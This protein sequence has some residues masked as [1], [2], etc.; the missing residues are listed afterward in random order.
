MW[1]CTG[2]V[3]P[4]IFA[5]WNV[6]SNL[7]Q[8]IYLKTLPAGYS[9]RNR[10]YTQTWRLQNSQSHQNSHTESTMSQWVMGYYLILK[11]RLH[12]TTETS[13]YAVI[14]C[15][16][17]NLFHHCNDSSTVLDMSND[18]LNNSLRKLFAVPGWVCKGLNGDH[19]RVFWWPWSTREKYH[20]TLSIWICQ[21]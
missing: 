10:S 13:K 6:C 11:R 18:F 9:P 16:H 17:Y 1:L 4:Y 7:F 20:Y 19:N 15:T 21:K 3:N 8:W 5:G 12:T 14:F 2:P